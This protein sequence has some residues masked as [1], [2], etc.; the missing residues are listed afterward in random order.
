MRLVCVCVFVWKKPQA[1]T[2]HTILSIST[3]N[4]ASVAHC[5]VQCATRA[6]YLQCLCGL[7]IHFFGDSLARNQHRSMQCILYS[8][9][10][11]RE[12]VNEEHRDTAIK[13]KPNF[14]S[15]IPDADLSNTMANNKLP[16]VLPRTVKENHHVDPA[17]V[18]R[19]GEW[20]QWVPLAHYWSK[21]R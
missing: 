6:K 8:S 20:T 16:W 21:Q 2:A 5:Q 11:N 7:P 4:Q 10:R 15:V 3:G 12:F 17:P 13:V 14:A 18:G 19:V 9:P 1:Y